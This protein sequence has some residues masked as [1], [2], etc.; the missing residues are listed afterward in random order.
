MSNFEASMDPFWFKLGITSDGEREVLIDT[1]DLPFVFLDKYIQLDMRLPTQKIFGFGQ[2]SGNI[3]RGEG[4][5][6]M[7]S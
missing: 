7:W 4:A 5:H 1:E 3:T 2:L 6:T